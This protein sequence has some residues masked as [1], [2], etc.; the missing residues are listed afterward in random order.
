M[1]T[2]PRSLDEK[3]T[4]LRGQDPAEHGGGC[5]APGI[6]PVGSGTGQPDAAPRRRSA[7]AEM[8]EAVRLHRRQRDGRAVAPGLPRPAPQQAA[9]DESLGAAEQGGEAAG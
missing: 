4:V 5:A 9:F 7:A 6:P 8:A 2:L 1:A 3:R